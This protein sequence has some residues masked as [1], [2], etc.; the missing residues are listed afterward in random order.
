MDVDPFIYEANN[1][2]IDDFCGLSAAAE[3]EDFEPNATICS[4][5]V[6]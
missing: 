6:I 1:R 4:L 2:P 5:S 3:R